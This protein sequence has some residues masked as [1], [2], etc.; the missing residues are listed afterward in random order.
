MKMHRTLTLLGVSLAL[1]V[2][3]VTTAHAQE[4]APSRL[5]EQFD[6]YWADVRD[7]RNI[8]KRLFL[9]EGRHEFVLSAGVIPN[10][11]FFVYFPMG[12]RYNY[13]FTED[14]SVEVSGSYMIK[15]DSELRSFLEEKYFVGLE[16]DLPQHLEW[17]AGAGV[18][19]T[20]LHG[21]VAVFDTKL[22]HFDFGIGLGVMALGTQVQRE[23]EEGTKGRTDVGGNVGAVV[24][25]Y[26]HDFIALRVDYRHY[27]YV[28]R[29]AD[30]ENRGLAYPAE[31]A[32]GLSFFT[33]APN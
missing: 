27:F 9:K 5:D 28:G 12:L 17:Q 11:D 13:F 25:F 26:V 7:V 24:R 15:Q 30:D 31:I 16:V 19:W 8:H 18:F 2:T 1:L 6:L 4:Q 32:F 29:D 22:G 33:E 21:K 23:G 3:S 10:D 20:P 14:L